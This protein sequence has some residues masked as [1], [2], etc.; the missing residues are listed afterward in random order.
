M[1]RLTCDFNWKNQNW[2]SDITASQFRPFWT[3]SQSEENERRSEK[4]EL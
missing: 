3:W 1:I 4:Q 2:I